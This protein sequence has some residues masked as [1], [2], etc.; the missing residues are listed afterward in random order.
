M[1]IPDLKKW[2]LWESI[3]VLLLLLVFIDPHIMRV[4]KLFNQKKDDDFFLSY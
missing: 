3:F 4:K 2:E 1:I